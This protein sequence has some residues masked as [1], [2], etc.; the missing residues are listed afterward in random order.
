VTAEQRQVDERQDVVDAVVVLGDPEGPA[1][2]GA[3][4]AGVGVRQLADRVGRDPRDGTAALQGPLL[5][6]GGVLGEAA[7]RALDEVAAH[8]A[9]VDDLTGDGVRER[10]VGADVEAQP[11]VRPLRRL[12]APGVDHV[13]LGAVAHPLE[14]VVEED[15]VRA[16]GVGAPQHDH[17]PI[18]WRVNLPAR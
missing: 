13:E 14:H 4:G 18:T 15:G 11:Q 8:E 1:H 16:A 6:R 3:R 12:G 5:D 17:V 10:D 2:L 7:G 9:G